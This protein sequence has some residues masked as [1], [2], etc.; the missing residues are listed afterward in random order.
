[1]E[2]CKKCLLLLTLLPGFLSGQQ[3][4]TVHNANRNETFEVLASDTL[5]RHGSYLLFGCSNDTIVKGYYK[6]GLKDSTWNEYFS[7]GKYL[8]GKRTGIWEFYNMEGKLYQRYDFSSDKLLV[9]TKHLTFKRD[10]YRIVSDGDT[11]SVKLNRPPMPIGEM[12]GWFLLSDTSGIYYPPLAIE[13]N[14][15]G[16]VE[17]IFSVLKDGRTSNFRISKGIEAGC[18]ELALKIA[19]DLACWIPGK[20][21]GQEVEVENQVVI[22]FDLGHN[23]IDGQEVAYSSIR[24]TFKTHEQLNLTRKIP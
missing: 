21:K 9:Y 7:K 11:L 5:V 15:S 4:K 1:M 13:N 14:V 10:K 16:S 24:A 23:L 18:D 22:N 3:L 12:T 2:N 6:Y 17:I 19:K 8:K 20:Y